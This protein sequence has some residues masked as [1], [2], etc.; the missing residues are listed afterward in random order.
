MHRMIPESDD[1]SR[2]PAASPGPRARP[3]AARPP[4][5]PFESHG[6]TVRLFKFLQCAIRSARNQRN[7]S[8]S[9]H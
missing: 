8:T 2:A 3:R 1:P 7:R 6:A 9:D 4:A 5:C